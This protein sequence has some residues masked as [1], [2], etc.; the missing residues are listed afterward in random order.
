MSV[1]RDVSELIEW[2]RALAELDGRRFASRAE[3]ER[4]LHALTERSLL[5]VPATLGALIDVLAGAGW[6]DEREDG[7]L[8][9]EISGRELPTA[10]PGASSRPS[11]LSGRLF[12]ELA[13]H[14]LGGSGA[15]GGGAPRSRTGR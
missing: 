5:P 10:R 15:A 3:L 4:S 11:A 6:I 1:E 2:E 12:R 7:S 13:L 9:L 14:V 8:R